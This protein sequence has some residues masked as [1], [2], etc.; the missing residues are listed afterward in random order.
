MQAH[1]SLWT[2]NLI[3]RIVVPPSLDSPGR[4]R[5][6]DDLDGLLSAFFRAQ[7]PHPWPE[8]K[9]PDEQP[10]LPLSAATRPAVRPRSALRSRLALAAS[11]A[12]FLA[13][14]WVLSGGF[15]EIVPSAAHKLDHAVADPRSDRETPGGRIHEPGSREPRIRERMILD[16]SGQTKFRIEVDLP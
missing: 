7:M 12:L 14:P 2:E 5:F 4:G 11:V 1:L 15:Q 16:P 6:G 3:M 13:G 10:L 9:S 8:S